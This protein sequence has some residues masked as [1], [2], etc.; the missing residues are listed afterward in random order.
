MR[1]LAL[2]LVLV[3]VLLVRVAPVFAD[4]PPGVVTTQLVY[5]EPIEFPPDTSLIIETG[6]SHCGGGTQGY[7]R[8]SRTS[9]GPVR[10]EPVVPMGETVG[11]AIVASPDGGFIA[12][13]T[14]INCEGIRLTPELAVSRVHWSEDG[15]VTW[16]SLGETPGTRILAAV[17][18][19]GPVFR[20]V[21]DRLQTLRF[22]D[23]TPLDD[24]ELGLVSTRYLLGG[25]QWNDTTKTLYAPDGSVI[26][27]LPFADNA[28]SVL[29][30]PGRPPVVTWWKRGLPPS[31]PF[32][33]Y[34][35]TPAA[36]GTQTG[37][38]R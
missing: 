8:V 9:R 1:L 3:P 22:L 13:T 4:D 34:L 12:A 29:A 21:S 15:G 30:Q 18:P 24:A 32:Y 28:P 36:D 2:V 33:Y 6:C 23:G 38:V 19:Q 20:E 5:A 35:T 27:S 37:V 10:I 7:Y 11:L 16:T 25:R 26:A 14:C 17:L 31:T